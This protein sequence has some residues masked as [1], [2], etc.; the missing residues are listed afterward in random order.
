LPS[1]WT[2]IAFVALLLM[3]IGVLWLAQRGAGELHRFR[4]DDPTVWEPAIAAFEQA[5]RE[6]PPSSEA[7]LF[8]GAS[9]IRFWETIGEDLAPL[10]IVA[11]GFGGAKLLDVHHYAERLVEPPPRA[12]VVAVGIN[13]LF[14]VGGNEASPHE[15]VSARVFELLGRLR[16]VAGGVPVYYLAI[17]P[18][19]LD[20]QGRDPSSQVNAAVRAFA[21]S[22]PGIGYI[23]ANIGMYG[24]NGRLLEA[25]RAW[26]GSQLSREG[27]RVWSAPIR[28]R[29]LRDLG[30]P[31]G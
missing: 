19:I 10:E 3:V 26:D 30:S 24:P 18:P 31:S 5:A 25:H 23:D 14:E 16:E 21:E 28:E 22:T 27:Y 7:V 15:E 2:R 9:T 4:S 6:D 8:I 20:P 13:D 17:R 29:L 1:I 11:R 12:I